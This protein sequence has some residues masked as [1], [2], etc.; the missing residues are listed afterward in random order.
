MRRWRKPRPLKFNLSGLTN[1]PPYHLWGL[2]AHL[3]LIVPVYAALWTWK[4]P[5]GCTLAMLV[6]DACAAEAEAVHWLYLTIAAGATLPP[7]IYFRQ[8]L[9]RRWPPKV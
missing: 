6:V 7:S 8:W 1:P 9:T 5:L 3:L 2:A 4:T